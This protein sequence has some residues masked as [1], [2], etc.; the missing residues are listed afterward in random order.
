MVSIVRP[1]PIPS[2]VKLHSLDNT[3]LIMETI[4]RDAK[5][6]GI[7]EKGDVV[8]AFD[9]GA[10]DTHRAL[11]TSI[12]DSLD[13][14]FDAGGKWVYFEPYETAAFGKEEYS[15]GLTL[16][17]FKVHCPFSALY[18]SCC[19]GGHGIIASASLLSGRRPPEGAAQCWPIQIH[20]AR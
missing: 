8:K 13:C 2:K 10:C 3:P 11:Q 19:G 12:D 6:G 9:Y 5:H 1:S 17:G 14:D 4:S 7:I 20:R 16:L 15:Q 18:V